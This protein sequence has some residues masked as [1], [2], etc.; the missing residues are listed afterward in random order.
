MGCNSK[1]DLEF[2]SLL[3]ELDNQRKRN[4][5]IRAEIDNL[6]QGS[7]RLNSLEIEKIKKRITEY[8]K[9]IEKNIQNISEVTIVEDKCNPDD[10]INCCQLIINS[11]CNNI[12]LLQ[13]KKE[14]IDKKL[15]K[16]YLIQQLK[17][18]IK[19]QHQQLELLKKRNFDNPAEI[20]EKKQEKCLNQTLSE[21]R[22][23]IK[24]KFLFDIQEYSNSMNQNLKNRIQN[25]INAGIDIKKVKSTLRKVYKLEELQARIITLENEIKDLIKHKENLRYNSDDSLE[26]IE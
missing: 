21:N 4:L 18:E 17:Q 8:G 12:S 5:S 14:K 11:I 25:L 26:D 22:L 15:Q 16:L 24:Q 2:Q 23:K 1:A 7:Y 9:N 10:D 19:D 3:K 6:K 13:K 20:K